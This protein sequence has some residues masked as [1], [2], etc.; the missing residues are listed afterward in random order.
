MFGEMTEVRGQ[1]SE[2]RGQR[3]DDRGIRLRIS[4][5][6]LRIDLAKREGHGAERKVRGLKKAG[7]FMN[8]AF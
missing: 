1:R 5:C 2:N 4:E 3:T 6:G 8:S 7:P